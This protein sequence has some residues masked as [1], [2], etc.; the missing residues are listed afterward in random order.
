MAPLVSQSVTDDGGLLPAA[1]LSGP[2]NT[3]PAGPVAD[4]TAGAGE[5]LSDRR[6]PAVG[7]RVPWT[8]DP[9]YIVREPVYQ[10]SQTA[11]SWRWASRRYQKA[12]VVTDLALTIVYAAAALV[13]TPFFDAA[14]PPL[15]VTVAIVF[16]MAC[17]TVT[18]TAAAGGYRRTSLGDGVQEYQTWLRSV[19]LAFG[20]GAAATYICD[21]TIPRDLFVA[22]VPLVATGWVTRYAFR[23]VLHRARNNGKFMMRTLLVG[24]PM[25]VERLHARFRRQAHHGFQV[26]GVCSSS[27]GFTDGARRVPVLGAVADIPQVVM[28]HAI[29]SVVV[30][31][32]Q[33]A[34]ESL[35]RLSWALGHTPAEL[36][37]SPGLVEVL[38]PRLRMRP[39]VGLSLLHVETENS[40]VRLLMKAGLDRVTALVI[41][42][43]I[44]PV[45]LLAAVAIKLESRG[46]VFF[47][48]VRVGEGG[49]EF[50]I[51]KLRSMF[52]DAEARRQS[53]LSGSDRDGPMFKM[54]RD[55]RV[56]RV[57]AFIRRYSIDELPQLFNVVNGEMSLVGPRPPLPA[58]VQTYQ[59]A[60]SRR[61][62]V[63]PGMTG[64]WQVSGRADLPWEESV[65]LD[66]RYVDNWSFSMDAQI[67]WKTLRAVLGGRGAY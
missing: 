22:A 32:G 18:A 6:R 52:V 3:N 62:L 48:Q 61:L 41:S 67:L 50:R 60:V 27:F 59:D 54:H 9:P 42:L 64:L 38:Q 39:T 35:R 28:D 40:K 24:D 53:L 55:P 25:T 13:L 7:S 8:V 16:S 34:G 15:G 63:R 14:V 45:L 36:I 44:A 49:G 2:P 26:V 5:F 57:G 19:G 1:V 29:D 56:T 58:E 46:P 4:M 10:A 33:V 20:T 17:V 12:L 47:R 23:R 30:E 31:P 65:Q 37:V 43:V 11:T 21:L 51:W 66:L